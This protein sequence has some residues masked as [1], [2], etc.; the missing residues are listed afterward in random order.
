MT[1]VGHSLCGLSIAAVTLPTGLPLKK[2]IPL[3]GLFL[4]MANIPDFPIPGWGHDRYDISH[5]LIV[6]LTL[7]IPLSVGFYL[8]RLDKM[9]GSKVVLA[10]LIVTWFSHIILDSTYNHGKGLPVLWPISNARLAL[11]L[12]WF[13]TLRTPV[14]YFTPHSIRVMSV[15]LLAYGVLFCMAM[16]FRFSRSWRF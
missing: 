16:A 4:V 14:N 7:A 1:P 5:S 2:V 3:S 6:T 10:R 9:T 12:P 13:E 8:L 11:P 15:E